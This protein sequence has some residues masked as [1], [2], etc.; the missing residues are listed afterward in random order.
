M[1]ITNVSS[2]S[3]K[4]GLKILK[5]SYYLNY[6]KK[7]I[8]KA[9]NNKHKFEDLESVIASVFKGGFDKSHFINNESRGYKYISAQNMVKRYPLD[10]CKIISKKL[11]TN[12]SEMKLSEGQILISCAGSVGNMRY[13]D[14]DLAGVLGSQD[15]IRIAPDSKKLLSGFL[16]AYLSSPT[17]FNYMQSL[18][19]GSVVPRIEPNALT[20]FPIPI[21]RTKLVEEIHSLIMDASDLRFKANSA[22]QSMQLKIDGLIKERFSHNIKEHK[23]FSSTSFK[24]IN[25]LEKRLDAPYNYSL[26]R[27]F[28]DIITSEEF[29]YVSKMSEVFHPMLF[30]KKQLKGSPQKGNKLYKSSSM[31]KL[32]PET[33]F[34]LSKN[35]SEK[36]E[37]LKVKEGWILISRTGTVGNVVLIYGH[38]SNIFIDDHMIRVIPKEKYS[39]LLYLFLKSFLGQE[40]IKF[41]K[42]GSVQEVINSDYI[43]RIP[44]PKFL[45]KPKLIEEVQDKVQESSRLIDEASIKEQKAIDLIEK[46]IE[47]WQK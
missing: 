13:V 16:Y 19:Y 6:G 41:Q 27:V 26:G 1:E 32:L 11:T 23:N 25:I 30:G 9:V 31:M 33:D 29:V 15:I 45:L 24:K 40:L 36:Y 34:W 21:F 4:E 38:Q 20:K 7:R 10:N 44:V 17:S 3:I 14:R 37:K 12:Y 5:P 28:N 42:Y 18:I 47:S 2:S 22:L 35:K 43:G 8:T 46:E 39:G